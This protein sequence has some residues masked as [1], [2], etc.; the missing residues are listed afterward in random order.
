MKG[1]LTVVKKTINYIL[2]ALVIF[3]LG[4]SLYI[5]VGA[6][7]G[8]AMSVFGKYVLE[9][10]TGSM[11]PTLSKG[12][13]IIV[14]KVDT[15]TLKENDIISFYSDDPEIKGKLVTHRIIGINP[16]G[17]FVSKGDANK[18]ED[19]VVVAPESIVGKYKRNAWI[20]GWLGSFADKRK[21]L[22]ILVII[23]V[24][25]MSLFEVR[26][27]AKLAKRVIDEKHEDSKDSKIEELKKAA[28]EAYLKEQAEKAAEPPKIDDNTSLDA[29]SSALETK[30]SEYEL[31]RIDTSLNAGDTKL[32]QTRKHRKGKRGKTK[33]ETKDKNSGKKDLT[34][35]TTRKSSK[36]IKRSATNKIKKKNNKSGNKKSRKNKKHK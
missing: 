14:E 28:V 5:L 19:K 12:N 36:N 6:A 13:Y 21:L 35:K 15:A 29:G 9:V 33:P 11:E 17:T 2:T 24:F 1:A 7:K 34:D 30:L 8:K 18:V 3:M 32:S 27:L 4:I 10:V 31:K 23:P 25:I 16:D 22:M 26:S 20:L